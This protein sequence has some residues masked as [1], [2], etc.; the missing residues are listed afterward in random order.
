MQFTINTAF[1]SVL[2]CTSF[3][4]AHGLPARTISQARTDAARMQFNTEESTTTDDL[5]DVSKRYD[6][7]V[8]KIAE[9]PSRFLTY[10]NGNSEWHRRMASNKFCQTG[11]GRVDLSFSVGMNVWY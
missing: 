1:N 10:A 2:N 4:A 9:L 3:E 7:D 8:K 11:K 6:S 5:I